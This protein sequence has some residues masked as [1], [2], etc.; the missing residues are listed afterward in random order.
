MWTSVDLHN[1][2]PNLGG[3]KLTRSKIVQSLLVDYKDEI[4]IMSSPGLVYVLI[5]KC[6]VNEI[7]GIQEVDDHDET[8]IR[9]VAKPIFKDIKDIS[10][11]KK[12]Y[13]TKKDLIA[14]RQ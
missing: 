14:C 1:E 13:Q 2:Y 6:K 4:I 5:F 12:V 3:T 7:I 9:C 11:D 10:C 8:H